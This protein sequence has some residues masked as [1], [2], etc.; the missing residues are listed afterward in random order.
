VCCRC[1]CSLK[2]LTIPPVRYFFSPRSIRLYAGGDRP[3]FEDVVSAEPPVYLIHN[4]LTV[5]ECDS[6]VNQARVQPASTVQ[7]PLQLLQSPEN[8]V[9]SQRSMLWQGLWQSA[10]GKAIEERIEQATGFPASHFT[11]F[12]V[13][14]L[15]P[16]SYWKPHFDTLDATPGGLPMATLTIFLTEPPASAGESS[17]ALVYP[18]AKGGPVQVR[19]QQGLAVI[20]HN[21]NDR[22]EFESNAVHALL[23][24][25][26]GSSDQP[27][28]VA[29]KYVVSSPISN[30]RRVVLPLVA[31]ACGGRL[32]GF[33]S[34]IYNL[35]AEQFGHETGGLYFDKLCIFAPVL[36]L[37]C[38]IQLAVSI[39][40]KKM[41]ASNTEDSQQESKNKRGK[42]KKE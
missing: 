21:W 2:V 14:R 37:L 38:L 20:H 27:I 26:G 30:S 6:L 32:P 40:Q 1:N 3:F 31:M 16:G 5:E 28:Y 8:F 33:L 36:A 35:L 22:H 13:D 7:D 39:V 10:S 41:A 34:T 9:K 4:L 12:V 15:K 18:S 42:K 25:T 19:P 23:E 29:R 11:D 17:A 24:Y